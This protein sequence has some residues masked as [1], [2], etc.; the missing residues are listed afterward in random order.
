MSGSAADTGNLIHSGIAA[1]HRAKGGLAQKR[2]VGHDAITADQAKFPLGNYPEACAVFASYAEDPENAKAETPWVEE[3]V[4]VEY[5]GVHFA[6]TLDQV[7]IDEHGIPRVWDVKTGDKYS[8]DDTLLEYAVQQAIYTIAAR[9][10]LSTDID[11]GGIIYTPWYGRN[12]RRKSVFVP[13]TTSID[14]CYKLLDAVVSRVNAVKTGDGVF[15]PSPKNCEY[16][17]LKPWPNCERACK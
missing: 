15:I 13:L 6:G 8:A 9:A 3:K 17:N 4:R 16:C 14:Q 11:V 5:R 1:F 2:R 10:T 7:R 12:R